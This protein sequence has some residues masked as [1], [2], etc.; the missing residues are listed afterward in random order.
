MAKWA[1]EEWVPKKITLKTSEL[2]FICE[3][4]DEPEI[5][6]NRFN[7]QEVELQ[8]EAVAVYDTIM[9]AEM[10]EQWP[11]VR[12]GITWFRQNYPEEYMVLLD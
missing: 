10:M 3:V 4:G 9:G 12:K 8:P 6:A 2:P 1:T 7:G 11:I 5:V